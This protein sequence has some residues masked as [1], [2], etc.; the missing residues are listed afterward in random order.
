MLPLINA[1]V[2]FLAEQIKNKIM[3][4][5]IFQIIA[6]YVE[7]ISMSHRTTFQNLIITA[8]IGYIHK[9][10]IYSVQK[11][12]ASFCNQAHFKHLISWFKLLDVDQVEPLQND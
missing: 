8:D 2:P 10:S 3:I 6:F 7:M 1:P 5:L 9:K 11:L 12:H 4:Y